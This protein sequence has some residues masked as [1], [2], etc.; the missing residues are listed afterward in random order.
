MKRIAGF[1]LLA[2]LF[3]GFAA[4]SCTQAPTPEPEPDP[5]KVDP[6]PEP[7]PEPEPEPV[8]PQPGTYHFVASPMQGTWKAGD[9]IYVHGYTGTQTEIVTLTASDI[10]A[11]GKTASAKL[12]EVTEFPADPDG[13]YAAWPAEAVYLFKGV[14]NVKTTY[15]HCDRLLTISYLEEDTFKFVDVS[16]QI[17][18]QVSGDFDNYAIC[19]NDRAGLNI[20]RFE[21]EYSS[22]KQSYNAKKND[23]YP[24]LY[25]S[26]T[27]GSPV[28]I[29]FPGKFSFPKGFTIYLA[30]GDDWTASY[31][32]SEA[33]ILTPGHVT[34]LGDITSQLEPYEGLA[35]KMPRQGTETK[36]AVAFNEL[37]GLCLSVDK[38]FLWAI[39]DNGSL[40]KISFDGEVLYN[41]YI[42]GEL[43]AV[44]MDPANGDLLL[45]NEEPVCVYRL[46]APNYNTSKV[47]LFEIPGTSRFGNAGLEGLTYYRDGM[48]LAGMQTGS[49]LFCVELATGEVVWKK[50]MYDTSCVSEVADLY[51]DP[52]TDWLWILDS[53]R[54]MILVWNGDVTELLGA[55]A[56]SGS[57]P[58]AL[59]VDHEHGCVWIGDD[60]GSTSYLYR[61]EF[62][63][64]DDAFIHE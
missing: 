47:K 51:Y 22:A 46:A 58:E 26:V 56:V 1:L 50:E 23:G 7:E 10:S 35:P 45:G 52:L 33:V 8:G 4:P 28:G 44:T 18:F 36:Y 59:C 38:D 25:G 48:I 64:L 12:N 9:Q 19:A 53:E 11:D 31:K 62:T 6:K 27:P 13:L 2:S 37:S 5:G 61:Y 41:K 14:L 54:K 60:Y 30:K 20:I 29:W 15:E 24:F 55:Y 57:N 3:L 21:A 63:G 17:S 39:D 43:E 34:E 49:Y 32:V 42:G 40:G 16:A